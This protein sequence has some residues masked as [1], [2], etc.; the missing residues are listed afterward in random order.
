MSVKKYNLKTQGEERISTNFK[1]KEFKSYS[2]TYNKLFSND[3]LIST[4]LVQKLEMLRSKLNC[5]ITIINGYRCKEHNTK[6]GG[7][8]NSTHLLGYAAD[9]SCSNTSGKIVCCV[10]Q[11]LGFKG[12]GYM[13]N[14]HVHLDMSPTRT[15]YGDETKKENGTYYSLTKHGVDFYKY[16]NVSKSD[17]NKINT[18]K[19]DEPASWAVNWNKSV[20]LGLIDGSNPSSYITREQAITIVLRKKLNKNITVQ[21]ACS[22]AYE[23]GYTDGSNLKLFATREQCCTLI[24]RILSG[25]NKATMDISVNYCISKGILK[26]DGTNYKLK[27]NCQRQAFVEMLFRYI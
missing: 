6:V 2:N 21:N 15:W 18:V 14:N 13:S 4:E 10:A 24:Y 7:S 12:I 22:Y 9:V 8:K 1:V 27:E 19:K 3:V 16:F 17:I 26:G 20:S 23:Q 5:K 11:D 25:N